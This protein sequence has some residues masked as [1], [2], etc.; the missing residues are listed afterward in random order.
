MYSIEVQRNWVFA[1]KSNVLIPLALQPDGVFTFDIKSL[2]FRTTRN[3]NLKCL[4][5][6]IIDYKIWVCDSDPLIFRSSFLRNFSLIFWRQPCIYS[7]LH[8][9][10]LCAIKRCENRI[11]KLCEFKVY[12][13]LSHWVEDILNLTFTRLDRVSPKKKQSKLIF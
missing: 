7:R 2:D 4:R 3:H 8:C 5:S 6:T 11:V 10:Q 1:T 13:C 12:I 9:L